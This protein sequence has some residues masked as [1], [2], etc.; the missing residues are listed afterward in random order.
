MTLGDPICHAFRLLVFT[1]AHA[2]ALALVDTMSG[3]S[4]HTG[5]WLAGLIAQS[6]RPVSDAVIPDANS[7]GSLCSPPSDL[8]TEFIHYQSD[9]YTIGKTTACEHKW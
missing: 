6:T 1:K 5:E 9:V 8:P 2:F 7:A 3:T 4:Y